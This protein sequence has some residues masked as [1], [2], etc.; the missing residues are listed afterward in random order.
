MLNR[1]FAAAAIA[2]PVAATMGGLSAIAQLTVQ[3]SADLPSLTNSAE[4]SSQTFLTQPIVN[5]DGSLQTGTPQIEI[6]RTTPRSGRTRSRS[7]FNSRFGTTRAR[8]LPSRRSYNQL[9]STFC[10]YS[11]LSGEPN[12]LGQRAFVTVTEVAG[13]SVFRYEQ[14]SAVSSAPQSFDLRQY[15]SRDYPSV[16]DVAATRS[17]TFYDTPLQSARR[18]LANNPSQYAE[19]LGRELNDPVVLQGFGSVDRLLACQEVGSSSIASVSE[20]TSR[21]F[22][23][24]FAIN[25]EIETPSR[26]LT[27][28]VRTPVVALPSRQQP[29]T[30]AGLPDGNYRFVSSESSG[31]GFINGE[32]IESGE[33]LFTFRKSGSLVTGNFAYLN[34]GET[35]CVS[36]VLQG[37]TV[38]G[39][40][41]T[42]SFGTNVLG[43]TYLGPGLSLQLSDSSG[44]NNAVLS[45]SGFSRVS[46]GE[47]AP[48]NSC[49]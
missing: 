15:D 39:E 16:A 21:R 43:R 29:K 5:Q 14:F 35:A 36:G 12:P 1:L 45:L 18:Q 37:N 42:N 23:T 28:T 38:V 9:F 33:R 47:V 24:P 44:D 46:A 41:Y 25:R 6:Y 32:A 8:T 26:A 48:P 4:P 31:G 22:G 3:T 27:L 49:R 20:L 10:T 11:P 17:I 34:S 19:L 30:I 7:E 2:F 13:T 40:A